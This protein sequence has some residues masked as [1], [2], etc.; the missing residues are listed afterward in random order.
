MLGTVRVTREVTQYG[1]CALAHVTHLLGERRTEASRPFHETRLS[2]R[3]VTWRAGSQATVTS[4]G[5][6]PPPPRPSGPFHSSWKTTEEIEW[7]HKGETL[8]HPAPAP[9]PCTLR[10]GAQPQRR[11]CPA[12]LA[13]ARPRGHGHGSW[14]ARGWACHPIRSHRASPTPG[15]PVMPEPERPHT[16]SPAPSRLGGQGRMNSRPGAFPPPWA[17]ASASVK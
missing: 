17:S 4:G 15:G 10:R 9:P 13:L 2:G 11:A 6:S 12:W 14:A 7:E 16:S 1:P 8:G 5:A 3:G